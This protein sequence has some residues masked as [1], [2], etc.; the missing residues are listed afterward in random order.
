MRDVHL[1]S[2]DLNLLPALEALLKRKNVSAAAPM[3][4]LSSRR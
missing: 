2:V 1:A 3:L 4:G